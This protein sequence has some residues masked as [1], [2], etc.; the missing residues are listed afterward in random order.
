M[1]CFVSVHAF[2]A[3]IIFTNKTATFT[4][5]DGYR[6][7]KVTLVKADLDGVIWRDGASGGRICYTNLSPSQLEQWGIP[8]N[9]IDVARVRAQKKGAA[10][11]RYQSLISAER[12][13]AEQERWKSVAGADR[14]IQPTTALEDKIRA[15]KAQI[16]AD[17]ELSERAWNYYIDTPDDYYSVTTSSRGGTSVDSYVTRRDAARAIDARLRA[18]RRALEDLLESTH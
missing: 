3:D 16:A 4:N 6:F 18:E 10:D 5:L 9:R 11:V 8:T 17:E 12:A 13:K 2:A 1:L 7:V 15:L 14:P